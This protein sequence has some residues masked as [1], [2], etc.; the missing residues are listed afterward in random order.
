MINKS[1][2]TISNTPTLRKKLSNVDK[3][4]VKID[5]PIGRR[6]LFIKEWQAIL[7]Y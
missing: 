4:K 7:L 2:S 5:C 1:Q 3:M 6:Q